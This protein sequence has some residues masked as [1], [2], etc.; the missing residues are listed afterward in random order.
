MMIT[1]VAVLVVA[2]YVTSAVKECA[3]SRSIAT[4]ST[5]LPL[6]LATLVRAKVMVVTVTMVSHQL[7]AVLSPRQRA[8]SHCRAEEV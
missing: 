8:Q 1:V 4:S 7:I 6:L 3:S 2:A 5:A